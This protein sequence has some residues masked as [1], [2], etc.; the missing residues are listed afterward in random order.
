MMT[1]IRSVV[2]PLA[3]LM[4]ADALADSRRGIGILGDSYSDEYQFYPPDRSTAR[5]WVE[6]LTTKRGLDFG[7]FDVGG[8]G[9]PRNQGYA[10]NWAR[11]GA[12]TEDLIRTGQHTGLAAQVARGEV[13]VV[14]IFIGGNDFINALKGP[15]P[16]AAL[17]AA[18]P[19]A[20]ANYRTAVQTILAAS[21]R[22]KLV[23]VTLPDIRHLPEFDG[24][25]RKGRPPAAL[26]DA[27]TGAIG[28]YNAQTRSFVAHDPRLALIDLDLI[29]RAATLLSREYVLV[30][31]RR[32]DRYHP[33]NALDYLFL[34]DGRHPGTLGQ[35]LMACVFIEVVNRKF[36]AGIRPLGPRELLAV[37]QSSA[38]HLDAGVVLSRAAGAP[39]AA[40]LA[41]PAVGR[42]DKV[43]TDAPSR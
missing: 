36:A 21:P 12:T 10:F 31:G 19:R 6:I 17:R 37:A 27:F 40:S 11:S 20:L 7:R 43:P 8:R 38:P 14:V 4:T 28:Q 13:G 23:L 29:T 32:L 5:N 41:K 18:L 1:T 25:V 9:E 30:A 33:A 34:A 2:V 15:D 39:R 22:V 24:P 3:L 35:G 26:A 16:A 42:I